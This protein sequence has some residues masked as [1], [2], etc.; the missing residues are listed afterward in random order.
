MVRSLKY[1]YVFNTLAILQFL[2]IATKEY[3]YLFH[4]EDV[5]VWFKVQTV[6][7]MI[8]LATL[9]LDWMV[10]GFGSSF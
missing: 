6:L 2:D 3:F 8:F 1:E 5:D 4:I 9:V 7:N 10:L